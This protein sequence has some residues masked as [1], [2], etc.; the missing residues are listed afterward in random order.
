MK[1]WFDDNYNS[2][3]IFPWVALEKAVI[4]KQTWNMTKPAQSRKE[5]QGSPLAGVQ[6]GKVIILA[7]QGGRLKI[8]SD[9]IY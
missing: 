7:C 5:K 1:M 9:C 2:F 6:G 4:W 3:W 8:F